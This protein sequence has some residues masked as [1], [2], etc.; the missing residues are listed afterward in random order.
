[1]AALSDADVQKVIEA[2]EARGYSVKHRDV[3]GAG[4]KVLLE[5]RYFRRIEKF[6]GDSGKWQ[7]WLF[8]LCVAV[9]SVSRDCV[10]AMEAVIKQAG[11]I[12]DVTKLEEVVTA[13]VKA[14]F[15]GRAFRSL[16]LADGRRSE[17]SSEKRVAER[18]R[19]LR[20][21]GALHVESA[22]QPEDPRQ[23]PPVLDVRSEPYASQGR[24]IAR[25]SGGGVGA[26]G[27]EA[28]DRVQ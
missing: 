16:V 18:R 22:F 24:Q 17:R 12:R 25:K 21:R 26:Q 10:L 5:E 3:M 13:D 28:Q 1:M 19:L 23:N 6:G 2:L 7:E 15:G 11:C 4:A 8:G 27:R 14:K 20:F 9:G